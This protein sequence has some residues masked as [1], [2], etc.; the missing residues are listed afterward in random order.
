MKKPAGYCPPEDIS[1]ARPVRER[2]AR[3]VAEKAARKL[4][5]QSEKQ[6]GVCPGGD[7][8]VRVR[9]DGS[10]KRACRCTLPAGGTAARTR[11]RPPTVGAVATG[12][13]GAMGHG[14]MG[15]HNH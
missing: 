11:R 6:V 4:E 8:S 13:T 1:V 15:A 5:Q 2:L 9:A 14:Q 10:Q 3:R 7:A 12:Q